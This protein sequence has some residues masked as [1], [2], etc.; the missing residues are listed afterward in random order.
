MKLLNTMKLLINKSKCKT[1]SSHCLKCRKNAEKT[2]P[3]VSKTNN[4]KTMIFWKCAICG[5]KKLRFI[6]KQ[7]AS[8]ILSNLGLKTPL[9]KIPLL[10]D[11]LF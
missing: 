8:G 3:R 11:T 2:N 7:E 9:N 5:S 10:G 1:K 6:K 4:G